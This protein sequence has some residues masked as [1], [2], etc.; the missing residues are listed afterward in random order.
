VL[1]EKS[2]PNLI[3]F[4][5]FQA[6]FPQ[7][8]FVAV[9]RHPVAVSLATQKWSKTSLT[10]LLEHWVVCHRT[11]ASDRP[12]LARIHVVAYEDLVARPQPTLD[13]V[14]GFLGLESRRSATDI[15][16][17]A[18]AAYFARWRELSGGPVGRIRARRLERRFEADVE[19]FGYSL[20]NLPTE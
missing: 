10:S 3:R 8:S 7:A 1:V 20:V 4:R 18:N 15:R 19:P 2:P 11:F 16:P 17:G 9:T 6:L 13:G 12:R 5:F 14:Y